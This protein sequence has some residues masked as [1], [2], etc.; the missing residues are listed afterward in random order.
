MTK[1]LVSASPELQR[2]FAAPV[3]AAHNLEIIT[4]D[5]LPH[6]LALFVQHQPA[7]AVFEADFAGPF[8]GF[9][10]SRTLKTHPNA[11]PVN[12]IVVSRRLSADE[13]GRV[14]ACRCDELL[15]APMS[16]DELHDAVALALGLPRRG[17]EAF[18]THVATVSGPIVAT[19]SNLSIDGLR[20]TT[21]V[22]LADG[23][24]LTVEIAYSPQVA[25]PVPLSEDLAD[26]TE[27]GLGGISGGVVS[28]MLSGHET[29]GESA[30]TE[31][32]TST[33]R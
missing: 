33:H 26:V 20:V 7:V 12:V 10:A 13:L 5:S 2:H 18:E 27:F 4:V 15:V 22:E 23:Q 28:V 31:S 17:T 32:E 30:K 9:E 11:T 21:D 24:M 16:A 25:Q 14:A 6:A 29:S 19:V 1:V 8:T 3:F